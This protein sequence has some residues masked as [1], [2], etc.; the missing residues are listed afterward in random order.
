MTH[1]PLTRR[2]ANMVASLELGAAI[3]GLIL[4]TS[5]FHGVSYTPAAR[6]VKDVLHLP[7]DPSTLVVLAARHLL[8]RRAGKHPPA[9]RPLD[10]A[11]LRCAL[12]LVGV[13]GFPLRH[14]M[15]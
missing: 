14:R 15:A 9:Q 5:H 11:L 13:L 4:P 3:T 2:Y 6:F 12:Q 7:G 8:R 1:V 10:P